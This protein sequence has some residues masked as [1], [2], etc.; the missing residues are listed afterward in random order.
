MSRTPHRRH[1]RDT[2][3]PSRFQAR[4]T[5][6]QSRR[7]TCTSIHT[8]RSRP[9]P[10]RR[11]RKN[12][13]RVAQSI[14]SRPTEVCVSRY[15]HAGTAASKY[16]LSRSVSAPVDDRLAVQVSSCQPGTYLSMYILHRY[17]A[18]W[19]RSS[20][21]QMCTCRRRLSVWVHLRGWTYVPTSIH[22][23]TRGGTTT[24]TNTHPSYRQ[25]VAT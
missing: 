15:A 25:L 18:P 3:H 8:N 12:L 4:L 21:L 19:I 7:P 20:R 24:H 23:R 6:L 11:W 22:T 10:R 13:D 2:I 17:L 5:A 9:G 16:L 1:Y 14:F